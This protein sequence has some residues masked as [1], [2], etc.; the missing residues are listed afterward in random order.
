M[1]QVSISLI[2][3]STRPENVGMNKLGEVMK[4]NQIIFKW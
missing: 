4:E 3:S 1:S 2:I